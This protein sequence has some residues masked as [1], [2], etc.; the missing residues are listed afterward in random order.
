M[1]AIAAGIFLI[2]IGVLTVCA[3]N[4]RHS[5][6]QLAE[7]VSL[8]LLLLIPPVAGNLIITLS[9][10]R[11]LSLIGCYVYYLGMD[12][13]IYA[14]YLYTVDYCRITEEHPSVRYLIRISLIA[15]VLQLLVNPIFHHAFGMEWMLVEGLS[16]YRMVPFAGQAV[17]RAVVYG[18]FALVVWIFYRKL[19][20]SPKSALKGTLLSFLPW[21]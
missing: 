11:L 1:R 20:T 2:L 6:R 14:L 8:L 7:S 15:D 16:Y 12:L 21:S 4:V 17:H 3:V 9:T 19:V 13:V 5:K 18:V 10:K